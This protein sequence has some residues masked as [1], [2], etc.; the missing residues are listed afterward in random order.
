[1]KSKIV[2]HCHR[3][4]YIDKLGKWSAVVSDR[5]VVMEDNTYNLYLP[6]MGQL[7]TKQL[8]EL[9]DELDKLNGGD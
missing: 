4:G 2:N 3:K 1:M 7:N 6:N 9:A 5:E 8:R